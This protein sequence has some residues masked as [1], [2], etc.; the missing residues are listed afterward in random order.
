MAAVSRALARAGVAPGDVSSFGHGMTVATNALLEERGAR[1]AL[2][3]TQGFT[4]VLELARQ[5]RPHLY[6]LCAA[7]PAPLVPPELRFAALER[8]SPREVISPLD[9]AALGRTLD[10]IAGQEVESVAVCLLH[11]WARPEH[12]R[13]VA[14]AVAERLPGVH[15]SASHDLL[16]V[17]REYERT[18]TTVIDA[19]LSPLLGGYL[20][21]LC[22]RA[23]DGGPPGTG[24][25]ALERRTGIAGG[26]GPAR[27][28]GRAVRT[29][30]RGGRRRACR[31]SV[32]QRPRPLIRHGRHLVRRR[33]DRRRRRAPVVGAGDRRTGAAAPDGRH[34]HRRSGWRQH[35]LGQTPAARCASARVRRARCRAPRPTGVAATSPPSPTR[36][37]CSATSAPRRRLPGT[38]GSTW[39]PP[40]LRS[41]GWP[42]SSASTST[43][44][45][46]GSCA[47]QTRRCCVRCAS[48][49]WSAASIRAAMHWSPSAAPGRC[50]PRGWPS[51]WA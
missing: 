38:S 41:E 8:N 47:W 25:H 40:A 28:L 11:S 33:R 7:R 21:R 5:T 17:F 48:R 13:R 39:R 31:S 22:S 4:D 29:G 15:V 23:A 51:S 35:R 44:R 16:A 37:C 19:Y 27:G 30:G 36:T 3:A 49:R 24:D 42:G 10:R 9:E 1:T 46:P 6:R 32:R 26:G 45:Q 18:S 2:I 34:P 12:E 14:Q 20:D 43:R 50:T